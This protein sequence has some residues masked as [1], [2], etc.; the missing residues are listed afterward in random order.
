MPQANPERCITYAELSIG[1]VYL[2][3]RPSVRIARVVAS[4]L[5][6]LRVRTESGIE[7][8]PNVPC[9]IAESTACTTPI[10][11][12][13][14]EK[15]AR[16]N[17]HVLRGCQGA[18]DDDD[19]DHRIVREVWAERMVG[20]VK[21]DSEHGGYAYISDTDKRQQLFVANVTDMQKR[22]LVGRRPEILGS[23]WAS[24]GIA[25]G[26][27]YG[28]R[29]DLAK[30]VADPFV[31]AG[32]TPTPGVGVPEP[33]SQVAIAGVH[34]LPAAV[35][36]AVTQLPADDLTTMPYLKLK[37][38]ATDRGIDVSDISGAGARLRII[39]RM[40]EAVA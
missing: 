3:T 20:V 39:A 36:V 10:D 31:T 4:E 5:I 26:E 27:V 38:I 11:G 19:W 34:E 21:K 7:T 9:F 13:I 2:V 29:V 33:P 28:V 24:S 35:V 15:G 37:K 25:G 30:L 6:T 23:P 8:Q 22:S 12:F 18:T 1:D 16:A 32:G 40:E 14:T 17:L